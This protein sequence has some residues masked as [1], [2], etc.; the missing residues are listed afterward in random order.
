MLIRASC[1]ICPSLFS[2]CTFF[3]FYACA[4]YYISLC[5]VMVVVQ[6]AA[7]VKLRS[8]VR[9][10]TRLT[11]VFPVT[12]PPLQTS[13]TFCRPPQALWLY[14]LYFPL[15]PFL[16]QRKHWVI[17]HTNV[18]EVKIA[19]ACYYVLFLL[20][21]LLFLAPPVYTL[22]TSC[23]CSCITPLRFLIQLEVCMRQ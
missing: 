19:P 1:I 22:M 8:A 16:P 10:P 4:W 18:E 23:V 3:Y 5:D 17:K 13:F 12:P 21:V 6:S 9:P 7:S 15:F 11:A 2:R 20:F 14:L